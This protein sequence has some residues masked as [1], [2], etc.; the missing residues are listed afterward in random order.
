MISQAIQTDESIIAK[1]HVYFADVKITRGR[2]SIY[3]AVR[4][5]REVNSTEEKVTT[6][7]AATD[8]PYRWLDEKSIGTV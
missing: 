5:V 1:L 7:V 6:F 4:R 8:L 2:L 3:E